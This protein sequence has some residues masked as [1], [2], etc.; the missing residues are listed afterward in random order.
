MIGRQPVKAHRVRVV[1]VLEIL[2]CSAF[3]P[4]TRG[5]Q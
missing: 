3:A 5:E 2:S 4:Q 1:F